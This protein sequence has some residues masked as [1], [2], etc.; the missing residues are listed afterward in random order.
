MHCQYRCTLILV[1]QQLARA[2]NNKLILPYAHL[3]SQLQCRLRINGHVLFAVRPHAVRKINI[4]RK[5]FSRKL[6]ILMRYS[7]YRIRQ[8][9]KRFF[10][11]IIHEPVESR[12]ALIKMEAMRSIYELCA[13]FPRTP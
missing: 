7:N 10:N 13:M 6:I 2:K 5:L 8:P 3:A 4:R 9:C 11:G 12:R 1:F